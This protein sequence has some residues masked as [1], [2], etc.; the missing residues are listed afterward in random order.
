MLYITSYRWRI[1]FCPNCGIK[2]ENPNQR[3]CKNCGEELAEVSDQL[4]KIANPTSTL[5]NPGV[6][7]IQQWP[8]RENKPYSK[9]TLGFGVASLVIAYTLYNIGAGYTIE[10][11]SNYY[12]P[13]YV[14][15]V[16]IIL[17]IFHIVG[18]IF[19]IASKVNNQHAR[20]LEPMNKFIKVGNVLGII[21]IVSNIILM[22]I[23]FVLI[24]L[25]W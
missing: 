19:G 6:Q 24:G 11:I 12:Y 16:F 4:S 3:F 14:P 18:L 20:E 23:A 9:K 15:I 21:G 1:M 10:P 13:R 17:S 5:Q 25:L 8:I 2:I 22:V 7:V